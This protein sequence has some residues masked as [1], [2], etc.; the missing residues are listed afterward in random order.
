MGLKPGILLH[1]MTAVSSTGTVR[2]SLCDLCGHNGRPVG[3]QGEPVRVGHP[4]VRSG[5]SRSLS[6]LLSFLHRSLARW[7]EGEEGRGS[8]LRH[9]RRRRRKV[10]RSI[11]A[12]AASASLRCRAPRGPIQSVSSALPPSD[13]GTIQRCCWPSCCSK[14]Q[15][16][17]LPFIRN[18]RQREYVIV[19]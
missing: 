12:E 4:G 17:N 19:L 7:R 13:G 11:H 14:Y 10:K 18:P 2:A 1:I 6:R 9:R 5:R 16:L 8:G 3:G 15:A